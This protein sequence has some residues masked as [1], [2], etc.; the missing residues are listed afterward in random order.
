MLVDVSLP[1]SFVKRQ[2]ASQT[3]LRQFDSSRSRTEDLLLMLSLTRSF[4]TGKADSGVCLFWEDCKSGGQVQAAHAHPDSGGPQ[5]EVQLPQLADAGALPRASAPLR[6]RC[7]S[8]QLLL[9]CC[10]ADQLLGA[11][12]GLG[13]CSCMQST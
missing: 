9:V 13:C 11:L 7:P 5:A 8:A 1:A 12:G 2:S 4:P 6:A 3:L 10:R